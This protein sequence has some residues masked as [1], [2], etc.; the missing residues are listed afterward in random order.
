[1]SGPVSRRRL[2]GLLGVGGLGAA[3]LGGD[4]VAGH[5]LDAP[6]DQLLD[7]PTRSASI[8]ADHQPT[9][10]VQ[11]VADQGAAAIRA[12]NALPGSPEWRI[13]YNHN[14]HR[15][16]DDRSRQIQ[17][18]ASACS[19]NVG[20]AIDFHVTVAPAQEYTITVYRLGHYGG[21]GARALVTSPRLRGVTAPAP[22]TDA[23][24]GLVSCDW[25]VGWRLRT[26][27]SWLS[28]VYLALLTNAAGYQAYV[29]FVVRDDARAADFCVVLPVTTHQAYNQYPQDSRTGKSLYLGYDAA[30]Q[31]TYDARAAKVSFDRP[32]AGNGWPPH[33]E[34][35]HDFVQWVEREG[36]DVV[37]ATS[38][39]LH[40]G[41]VRADR[42][43]AFAHSGHD[44]YWSPQMRQAT[45]AAQAAGTHFAFMSANT[46]YWRIRFEPSAAGVP[47]RV[48]VCYKTWPDPVS[49]E[50]TRL[51]R[52]LGAPEQAFVGAMV[53]SQ[54]GSQDP[55]TVAA[56]G[57]WFW[58]GSGARDGD[59]IRDLVR[60]EADQCYARVPLPAHRSYTLLAESIYRDKQ[61]APQRHNST[62]YQAPSGAWVFCSGTFGWNRGLIRPGYADPRIQRGTRNLFDRI[63]QT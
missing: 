18:Y 20:E 9:P 58:A 33:F 42:Y 44:E 11:G 43:R 41:R 62:L 6:P 38:V 55:L 3:W 15:P 19:V 29:P 32:Y 7:E 5:S 17:G 13:N 8:A 35:D 40:A 28:G 45:R 63:R 1:M 4:A 36:Y 54:V 30:G 31:A 53:R 50:P 21:V 56:D 12:E 61:G 25:P 46:D 59:R 52:D 39:D 48:V 47:D 10:L 23:K 22:T 57:H 37:Y 34:D 27:T 26:P 2:L 24:S 51:W 14:G 49:D 60:V 16:S